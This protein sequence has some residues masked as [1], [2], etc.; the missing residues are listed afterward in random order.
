MDTTGEGIF[1]FDREFVKYNTSK[2]KQSCVA[3]NSFELGGTTVERV[4]K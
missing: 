4:Q 2:S 1:G 3:A